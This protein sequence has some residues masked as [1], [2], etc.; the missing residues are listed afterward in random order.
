MNSEDQWSD[1]TSDTGNVLAG[2]A[3]GP[4]LSGSGAAA[5]FSIDYERVPQAIADLEH[6]AELSSGTAQARRS[7]G[8]AVIASMIVAAR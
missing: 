8:H 7:A 1:A 5:G 2:T 6:A 4:L 3:L